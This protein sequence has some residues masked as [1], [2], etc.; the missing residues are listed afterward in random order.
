MK[1]YSSIKIL[2][3]VLSV[4]C[5]T[6]QL[7]A[8]TVQYVTLIC[9][10]GVAGSLALQTNQIVS[11]VGYDWTD[12]PQ[13]AGITPNGISLPLGM[14]ISLAN[15]GFRGSQ[16][17]QMVTGLTRVEVYSSPSTT[18]WATFQ[19]TTPA[20]ATV[21][22]N[23]V[24]ADAIVIPASTTGNVQIILETSPDLVNW[25]AAEPGTYSANTGTNRFF[26]VR[27]AAE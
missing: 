11:V 27:A 21:I 3:A 20:C 16:I 14:T 23:Y 17:P 25:T 5:L 4:I 1:N 19:I 12:N 26:R 18:T 2:F 6:C 15:T 13:L 22:S 9:S 24:P 10:N 8:Q 7:G